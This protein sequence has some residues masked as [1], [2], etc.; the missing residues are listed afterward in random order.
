MYM[1]FRMCHNFLSDD[2]AKALRRLERSEVTSNVETSETEIETEA[3]F[4]EE[5]ENAGKSKNSK[6][7]IRLVFIH[8][9]RVRQFGC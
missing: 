9:I 7:V 4:H 2:L 6:R 3:E 1:M 5:E 8:L